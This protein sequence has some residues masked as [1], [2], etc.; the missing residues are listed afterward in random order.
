MDVDREMPELHALASYYGDGGGR[1]W[2]AET[3]GAV[4][5]MIATRPLPDG[6][7]E[8]CRVYVDPALHGSGLGHTLLDQA[9]RHAI[10]AGAV[11]LM[12]WSDTRFERA[13]RFYERRS[14]V[15]CGP[16]R[17]LD[18]ISNSLEFAYAKPVDDIWALDV[19]AVTSAVERLSA[20]LIGCVDAGASVSFLPPL[21]PEKARAFW[22]RV[23]REVAGGDRVIMAGW[24][25]GMLV[26]TGMLNLGMPDN[27]RHRGEIEK[28]L[29]DPAM[30]RTGLGR[31]ILRRLENAA[32]AQG[33]CLL[34][35]DTRLGD[36]AESL[37]RAEGWQ[38][39][40]RIPGYARDA[41]GCARATIFFWKQLGG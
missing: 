41:T 12:L 17:V 38:E 36:A 24:R 8:I 33:R 3:G 10:D 19:A 13:H 5:G 16:I 20:I 25:D 26:G 30:R 9:E 7:W 23:V 15:R 2:V 31:R 18:D 35:L 29:V 4:C 40:G 37:Y 27:Q 34:T 11:R 39:A 32:R 21:V 14:Y 28:L 6:A 22:Q 1:L